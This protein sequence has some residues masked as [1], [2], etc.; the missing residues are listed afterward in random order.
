ML[1]DWLYTKPRTHEL[2]T[3]QS[4]DLCISMYVN[5]ILK[6][7]AREWKVKMKQRWQN[8]AHCQGQSWVYR[9]FTTPFRL[10]SIYLKVVFKFWCWRRL[11]RSL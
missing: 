10:L 1:V 4:E 8:S 6:C 5:S 9:G 2:S 11:F 3:V 7:R